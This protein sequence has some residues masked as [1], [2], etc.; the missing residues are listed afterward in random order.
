M[1]SMKDSFRQL[2]SKK[3]EIL[4][5][6]ESKKYEILQELSGTDKC[7]ITRLREIVETFDRI[8]HNIVL[9]IKNIEEIQ[10]AFIKSSQS[11]LLDS[12]KAIEEIKETISN[13]SVGDSGTVSG[14]EDFE[15]RFNS[16][17]SSIQSLNP[18]INEA[19][20]LT[21]Q[22]KTRLDTLEED[23]A[24]HI[25]NYNSAMQRLLA[26]ENLDLEFEIQSLKNRVTE[27]EAGIERAFETIGN[28]K[29][30]LET[31]IARVEETVNELHS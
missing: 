30:E 10:N 12:A 5:E 16:M 8:E 21:N 22:N 2:E 26:I 4:G 24:T 9:K 11:D 27:T 29:T 20:T 3:Y 28:V 23:L 18:Q 6:L 7:T 1:F 31:D 14:I 17:W 15:N 25:T 19:M 13:L